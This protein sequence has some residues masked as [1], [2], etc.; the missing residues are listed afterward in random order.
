MAKLELN[1]ISRVSKGTVESRRLRRSGDSVPG[2]IYG[3]GKE[4]AKVTFFGR[5]IR[6]I[7]EEETFYSHIVS[8]FR[9]GQGERVVLRELQRHPAKQDNVLHLDF[10]RVTEDQKINVRIPL[11]FINEAKCLGVRNQGGTLAK[12]MNE[13]EINCLSGKMPD[14]IEVDVIE[15][16]VHEAIH[17]SDLKVP[18]GVTLIALKQDASH[19]LPV[20]SVH[21]PRGGLSEEEEAEGEVVVE[22]AQPA[23]D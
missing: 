9:E 7:M 6:K 10:M 19:D 11:H 23:E 3:G 5:E 21:L 22:A 12:T 20:V 8:V 2:I 15:L 14:F 16:Q 17:L 13:V 1:A 18:E 4:P